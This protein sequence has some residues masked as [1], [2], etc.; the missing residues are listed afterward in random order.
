M[1]RASSMH[2]RCAMLTKFWLENHL[3]YLCVDGRYYRLV[4]WRE[5]GGRGVNRIHLTQNRVQQWILVNMVMNL[6]V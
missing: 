5:I 3:E 4:S 1:A 6:L 2:R